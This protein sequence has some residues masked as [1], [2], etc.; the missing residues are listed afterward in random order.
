VTR[1]LMRSDE[2]KA[3]VRQ[4]YSGIDSETTEVAHKYYDPEELAQVPQIAVD[5]ALGVA[6]HLRFVDITPGETILDLG[7]G[8]GI[9]TILA[10]RRTGPTGRMIG[11]DFL[12][13]ML[14]RTAAAAAEA[15]L[16]N[17]ETLE[18]EMEAIPLADDS[19]DHVISNGVINLSPRKARALAECT[20]VLRPGGKFSVSDLT[21]VEEEL[22][23]EVL[24]HPAAWAGCV[25][26]ALAEGEFVRKLARAGFAEIEVRHREPMSVEGCALYPLFT[27]D[28][29]ELMRRLIPPER[30]E[31]VATSIVVTARLP[32]SG[33][34]NL[35]PPRSALYRPE[36]DQRSRPT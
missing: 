33:L 7:C 29:I 36:S 2:I 21:I 35:L 4:A 10:A 13:E 26:G 20:R 34:N 19:V 5:R 11:L 32:R 8:G 17:V 24:T 15:G 3:I 9:D 14:A 23:P 28:L 18:G 1:D 27:A 6:N 25:S 31:S 22:P 16:D 12:P 30:Q